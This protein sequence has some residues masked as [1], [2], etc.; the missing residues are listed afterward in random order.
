MLVVPGSN[1]GTG[2]VSAASSA[3]ADALGRIAAAVAPA[4]SVLSL[5]VHHDS[6]NTTTNINKD[7]HNVTHASRHGSSAAAAR[8]RQVGLG[9]VMGR[10]RACDTL[11]VDDEGDSSG[12]D[13]LLCC[14]L[15][16]RKLLW[17][18]ACAQR[19]LE[20]LRH[21]KEFREYCSQC[22]NVLIIRAIVD[23]PP[24]SSQS[25]KRTQIVGI[26]AHV[27]LAFEWL[28][29]ALTLFHPR[30]I[31]RWLLVLVRFVWRFVRIPLF[32]V[33]IPP[34][35]LGLLYKYAWYRGD[36]ARNKLA[37][38]MRVEIKPF[39]QYM[40]YQLFD[41]TV[42]D[43]G[44]IALVSDGGFTYDV[45]HWRLG[46]LMTG[47]VCLTLFVIFLVWAIIYYGVIRPCWRRESF[48]PVAYSVPV[49]SIGVPGR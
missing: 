27:W 39:S 22:D 18:A 26:R 45:G 47:L 7:S 6:N 30:W 46:I 12:A 15:R 11:V 48:R 33:T 42:I 29:Y 40:F 49:G 37:G 16:C 24:S 20:S 32:L 38:S 19:Q 31:V 10:C 1:A 9:A 21:A 43:G 13:A 23:G 3:A 28:V 17:H 5:H 41:L 2:T 44:R 8:C 4:A 35:V 25:P 36:V 34:Y 14:D